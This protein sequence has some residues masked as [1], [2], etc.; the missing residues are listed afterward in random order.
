MFLSFLEE[1]EEYYGFDT[2]SVTLREKGPN[3]ELLLVRFF[4]HLDREY[5]SAFTP[6]ARKCGP[7]KPPYFDT[8]HAV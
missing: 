8:F 3:T 7:G 2:T 4:S 1:Q 6:H 5:L